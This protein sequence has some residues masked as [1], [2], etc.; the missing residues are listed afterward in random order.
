[1]VT[2]FGSRYATYSPLAVDLRPLLLLPTDAAAA[3]AASA[4]AAAGCR[5]TVNRERRLIMND[6][7][8]RHLH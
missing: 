4:A 8:S 1:L 6:C 5:R 7:F 2:G 3:A